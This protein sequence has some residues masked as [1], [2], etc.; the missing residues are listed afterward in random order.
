VYPLE[1]PGN[2]QGLHDSRQRGDIFFTLL[3][4]LMLAGA[5]LLILENVDTFFRRKEKRVHPKD[6]N[7]QTDR[8]EE[9]LQHTS[10]YRRLSVRSV[11]DFFAGR[12]DVAS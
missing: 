8:T 4:L 6:G 7:N 9:N 12:Y 11:H 1:P 10:G 5:R 2:Q 3:L